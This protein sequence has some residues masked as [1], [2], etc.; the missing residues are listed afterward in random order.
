MFDT[1]QEIIDRL[2]QTLGRSVVLDDDEF[3]LVVSSAHFHDEDPARV[4]AL[5]KRKPNAAQ[6][7]H[8]QR[9]RLN[10]WHDGGI[11]EPAIEVGMLN[12]RYCVPL[13]SRYGVLGYLWVTHLAPLDGPAHD[14]IAEGAETL[15]RLLEGTSLSIDAVNAEVEAEMI[16]LLSTDASE[17][18]QA[19]NTLHDLGMYNRSR[20]F[21]SFCLSVPTEW[22]P[23][24]AP[25]PRDVITRVL[26]RGITAPMIDAYGFVPTTPEVFVLIGFQ[27][28]PTAQAI[29]TTVDGMLREVELSESLVNAGTTIGVGK[30]VRELGSSWMS[31]EQACVA[32]EV[33]RKDGHRAAEWEKVP[34]QAALSILIAPPPATHLL[35]TLLQ[36]LASSDGDTIALLESYFR[37]SADVATVAD[38]LSI[39]RATVYSRLRRLSETAG[40]DLNDGDARFLIQAWLYQR[41]LRPR[42]QESGLS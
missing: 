27:N 17:R 39:H 30:P 36:R 3:G 21:L 20:W 8:L 24:G 11:V 23:W 26:L 5:L 12:E 41:N 32:A 29:E 7:E 13:R 25:Q 42:G 22:T 6:R 10:T 28:P 31:F 2:A 35:P 18:D 40:I 33:A 38:E 14:A 37:H 9:L 15:T 19:A 1:V 16:A 34:I 4:T